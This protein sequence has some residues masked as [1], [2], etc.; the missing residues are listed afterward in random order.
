M[1]L[2]ALEKGLARRDAQ[3]AFDPVLPDETGQRHQDV[4]AAIVGARDL[5]CA[6]E[7]NAH[8]GR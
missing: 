4:R 5:C 3:L 2:K 6:L 7:E 1:D 8:V